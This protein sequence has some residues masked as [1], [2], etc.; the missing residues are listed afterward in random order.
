MLFWGGGA[1]LQLRTHLLLEIVLW[2][3]RFTARGICVFGFSAL[4]SADPGGVL[5]G[6]RHPPSLNAP[7]CR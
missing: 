1:S 2:D 3:F 4:G 5:D 7:R 6:F